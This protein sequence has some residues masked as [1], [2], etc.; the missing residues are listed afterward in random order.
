MTIPTMLKVGDRVY[1]VPINEY[2]TIDKIRRD[3]RG[4]LIYH[5][6][7]EG[8]FGLYHLCRECELA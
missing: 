6:L 8:G 4:D 1:I 2:G 3:D 5:V 7:R